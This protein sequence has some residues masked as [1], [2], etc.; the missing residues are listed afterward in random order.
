MGVFAFFYFHS[1]Y[2]DI[3]L[4]K[5]MSIASPLETKTQMKNVPF[6]LSFANKISLKNLNK[7]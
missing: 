5:K 3:Q 6:N 2:G 7:K 1:G 4:W